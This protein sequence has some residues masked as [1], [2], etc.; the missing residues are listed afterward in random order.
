MSAEEALH[1]AV[2]AALRSIAG[3]GVHEAGPVQAALPHAVVEI[4]PASDWGHKSGDGREVRVG[5][6]LRDGGEQAARLRRLM[7]EAEAVMAGVGPALPGWQVVTMRFVRSRV[8]REAKSGWAGV[9]E[10]RA[11][12]LKA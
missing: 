8:V 4:G 5:A 6:V 1:A 11:R 12:M 9:V 7:G 10:Y 2:T 3:L